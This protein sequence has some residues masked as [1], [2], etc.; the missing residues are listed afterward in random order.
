MRA[1]VLQIHRRAI[2]QLQ[3]DVFQVRVGIH[4]PDAA[5]DEFHAVFLDDFA[6]DVEVALAHGVHDHICS[7]T[8]SRRIR[9]DET[10]I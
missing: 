2:V 3:H 10:S 4:Q 7:V 5:H 8:P 6:A 9:S 1:H